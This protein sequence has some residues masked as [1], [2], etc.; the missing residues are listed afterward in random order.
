MADDV[1]VDGI[2]IMVGEVAA[3]VALTQTAEIGRMQE[4]LDQA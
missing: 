3:D 4:M 2:D 1:A